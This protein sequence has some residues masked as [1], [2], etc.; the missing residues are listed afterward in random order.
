MKVSIELTLAP[1]QTDYEA[2]IKT[3]IR[4]LRASEFQVLE[5]SL[6]THI[7]GEFMPLMEFLTAT[8]DA[9]FDAL[10]AGMIHLKIV[11]TDRS[12]YQPFV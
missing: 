9:S 10:A 12:D 5:N 1:L 7:Y 3:F 6:S 4:C 2:H 8:I 11:K